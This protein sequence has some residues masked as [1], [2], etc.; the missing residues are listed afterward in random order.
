MPTLSIDITL[1]TGQQDKLR[2]ALEFAE[3][4]ALSP[5][6]AAARAK[7]ICVR[8]LKHEVRSHLSDKAREI[9]DTAT[10]DAVEE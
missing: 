9:A 1:S 10:F 4:G 7:R 3:G 8:A 2:E 5:A 6:E